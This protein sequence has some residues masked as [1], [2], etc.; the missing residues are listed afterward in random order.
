MFAAFNS[1][2]SLRDFEANISYMTNLI[3]KECDTVLLNP[4]LAHVVSA[5]APAAAASSLY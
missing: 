3:N 4:V 2:I 5:A 1:A